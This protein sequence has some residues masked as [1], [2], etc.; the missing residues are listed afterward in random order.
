MLCTRAC[1]VTGVVVDEE[2]KP[3]KACIWV[4]Q[5]GT[6][7]KGA[8]ADENGA[9]K[10]TGLRA[11]AVKLRAAAMNE[12][13]ADTERTE[14]TVVAGRHDVN[15]T[16]PRGITVTVRINGW[17]SLAVRTHERLVLSWKRTGGKIGHDLVQVDE[18]G[19][20]IF[21]TVR[22]SRTYILSMGTHDLLS[23][24]CLFHEDIRFRTSTFDAQFRPGK[25]ITGR[26]H[27]P[28]EPDP[29]TLDI[30]AI[31]GP[32]RRMGFVDEAGGFRITGLPE[33]GY[34]LRARATIRGD[35]F[36][37]RGTANTGSNAD[38]FLARQE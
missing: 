14:S 1:K 15:L 25:T 10:V 26:L 18:N 36:R 9:F 8:E 3:I 16:L 6:W 7:Q 13:A 29:G 12:T 35:R 17:K 32:V 34:R 33:G 27:L 5:T 22:P 2:G 38:V 21:R 24:L 20:A 23:P 4:N 30:Q 28:D 19:H 37:W 11:G 31:R